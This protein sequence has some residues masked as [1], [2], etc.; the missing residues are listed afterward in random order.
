MTLYREN[1]IYKNKSFVKD[2]SKINRDLA[3]VIII[4]NSKKAF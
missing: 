4:D 3:E 1:C 2:L